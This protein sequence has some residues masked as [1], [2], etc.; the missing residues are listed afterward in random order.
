MTHPVLS[1]NAVDI[2]FSMDGGSQ[3]GVGNRRRLAALALSAALLPLTTVILHPDGPIVSLQTILLVYLLIAVIVALVGGAVAGMASAVVGFLLA[4]WFFTSPFQTWSVDDPEN[5]VGLFVFLVVGTSVG[6]L[7]GYARQRAVEAT[8]SRQQVEALAA[9]TTSHEPEGLFQGLVDRIA[10]VFGASSVALHEEVSGQWIV[11]AHAGTE[12][13]SDLEVAPDRVPIDDRRFLTLEGVRLTSEDRRVLGALAAQAAAAFERELLRN[14]AAHVATMAETDRLRTALLNAVS[15]DLRTPLASIKASVTSLIETGI[16]WPPEQAND[17]LIT[18]H[19]ETERL[20]RLV[21]QLLDAS[22][23][24]VGAVQVVR[25]PISP[26]ELVSLA[27]ASLSATGDRLEIDV[28]ES[29][30]PVDTDPVLCERALAN[31]I[32]NALNHSPETCHVLVRAVRAN[33]HIAFEVIDDG[34]GIPDHLR[35]QAFQPFQ[36]LDDTRT[37]T[38]VGLGLAVTRG[39]LDALGHELT[40]TRKPEG[41]TIARVCVAIAGRP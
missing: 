35:T 24:H 9:A 31:L 8:R 21:G 15:H 17:F 23:I 34:P 36:R 1:E 25:R 33:G 20:N 13:T 26:D 27:V 16:D 14:E 32:D 39:F 37:S 2:I 28:S 29:L 11:R 18:I 4:N 40:L 10:G 6:W 7:V 19:D 30:P 38:G 12:P 22:R 41:G 5:V 3:A